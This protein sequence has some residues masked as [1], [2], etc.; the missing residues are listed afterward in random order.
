MRLEL[1]KFSSYFH[2]SCI[3]RNKCA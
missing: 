1:T 3:C 2:P